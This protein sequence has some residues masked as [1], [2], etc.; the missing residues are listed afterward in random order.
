ME[1]A[2]A[3][4]LLEAAASGE[5]NL[6]DRI[7]LDQHLAECADCRLY[8]QQLDALEVG[9]V[10]S[11]SRRYPSRLADAPPPAA[12]LEKIRKD[13]RRTHMSRSLLRTTAWFAL[14]VVFIFALNWVFRTLA[15]IPKIGSGETPVPTS[16]GTIESSPAPSQPAPPTP[17]PSSPPP[18]PMTS[19]TSL[20]PKAQFVLGSSL[21]DSPKS[22]PIYVQEL[23]EPASAESV[24]QTAA[25]LGLDAPVYQMQGEG[26][27][28][29]FN[30]SDGY[31]MLTFA[32]GTSEIFSYW[33]DYPDVL[34]E[35]GEP[36]SFDQASAAA[37]A[38]LQERG[39]L[40]MP[41]RVEPIP[42]K[43]GGVHFVRLLD[44]LPLIYG[45]GYSPSLVDL[46]VVVGPDLKVKELN[47]AVRHFTQ[48]SEVPI[49]SAQQAWDRFLES[50]DGSLLRYAINP[51]DQASTLQSWTRQ[52]PSG[53]LVHLYGYAEALT[54]A[55]PGSA[56]LVSLDNYPVTGDQAQALAD[57]SLR[58]RFLHTW[59]QLVQDA[60]GRPSF[61]IQGWELSPFEDL[62]LDGQIERQ[63]DQ[64]WLVSDQ[65]RYILPDL[66]AEV[67]AGESA[68]VR[69]VESVPG[70]L[71]WSLVTTGQPASS[72]Y[73][74]SDTCGGGGGG[75]GGQ[76]IGGG[77]FAV[78]QLSQSS[79]SQTSSAP[80]GLPAPYKPGD[81]VEGAA[82]RVVAVQHIYPN[83]R[84]VLEVSLSGDPVGDLSGWS[85]SL[86]G[87]NI[88]DLVQYQGL[89]MRIWGTV[90]E[91][92]PDGWPVI[93]VE[94]FEEVYTGLRFQAWLGTWQPVELGGKQVLLF[95]D[96]DGQQYI[97]SHSISYG[98]DA[99]IGR[100]GD[101]VIIE[102]LAIP[103]KTFGGY[104]VIDESGGSMAE[105]RSDLNGYQLS[106]G[107]IHV[108]DE[109][110]SSEAQAAQVEG[111]GIVEN[112]DLVYAAAS[113]QRCG[114]NRETDPEQAPWLYVQ[115]VWRF[116]G[117]FEDGR[118]FEIQVQALPDQYVR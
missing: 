24:A 43:P 47:Y 49:L 54:S 20:F 45:I 71:D 29:V 113:L 46:E 3:M 118:T 109:S 50:Q 91:I 104:P 114:G 112:V 7:A 14:A 57:P 101:R 63:G 52:Y 18:T 51:P 64:A 62:Y 68:S 15:P 28:P 39:L 74:R 103:G 22:L 40:D 25:R 55:S 56:P 38:Y 95:T 83:G 6:A 102:G 81:R 76:D 19:S 32:Y 80:T 48:E 115:P 10:R 77:N 67:P 84:Q 96:A 78:L 42:Q 116:T 82:G 13:N 92:G 2:R 69:G 61:Q 31:D 98:T 100:Q 94:R 37:T 1:H 105:G 85:A 87:P 41:Y 72:G 12:L 65:G 93:E 53:Q 21:P 30:V 35:N 36:P 99:A 16:T 44:G 17:L 66:P 90:S 111:R 26:Q 9:L 59:G 117:H 88:G 89:P 75:G 107:N 70:E 8:S 79:D 60:Q 23:P 86:S 4:A 97:L 34:S 106:S 110:G 5:L 11:L 73:S 108:W 58:S 33:K 27:D